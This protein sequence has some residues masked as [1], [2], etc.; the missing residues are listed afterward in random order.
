MKIVG[1]GR[2]GQRKNP[3]VSY[4]LHEITFLVIYF[5]FFKFR[6]NDEYNMGHS[7]LYKSPPSLISSQGKTTFEL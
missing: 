4:R 7:Y 1:Q 3:F 6:S 2:I 5:I